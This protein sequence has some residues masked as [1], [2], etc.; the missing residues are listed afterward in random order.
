MHFLPKQP[1]IHPSPKT[2]CLDINGPQAATTASMI[3]SAGHGS[4]TAM[5]CDVTSESAVK[6]TIDEIIRLH[7][8]IDIL[9]N[10]VGIGGA[11]GTAVE[12]DMA[13]WAK[14]M[15]INVASMVIMAKY[16][17]PIMTRN[18]PSSQGY[19]G[20]IVNM[21]SVAGLRGG[22]PHL[23]Y[24]T[25][26]GAIVNMTRAMASHHAGEGIRVN[27]VCPGMVYTPMMYGGGMSE[28]ARESRKNR[29]LLRTEG[30]G[31]DVGAA[32]RFLSGEE[33]RWI[34]GECSDF[35]TLDQTCC[36]RFWEILEKYLRLWRLVKPPCWK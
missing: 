12:V 5:T 10:I 33:S 16:C 9:V 14:G 3:T 35:V 18:D 17:I 32:V 4:A 15:E 23:L 29:S 25:S 13:D 8:R 31:W 20:A 1:L 26:K 24:P 6:A 22:T 21:A 28:E 36:C 30:Y 34:T 19:R 11:R 27:C 2:Q 7:H